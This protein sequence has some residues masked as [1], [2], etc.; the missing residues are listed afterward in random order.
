MNQQCAL[1]AKKGNGILGSLKKKHGQ[2]V[3]GGD[4]PP[5]LCPGRPCPHLEYCIHFWAP[6]Y[7]KDRDLLERVQ[8]KA[9]KVIKGLEHLACEERLG[10]VDLFSL[11]KRRLR[12]DVINVYTYL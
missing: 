12:G 4:P 2:Q 8:W 7:K 5:L 9:T 3:K 1:V 10:D 11:E 6:Q